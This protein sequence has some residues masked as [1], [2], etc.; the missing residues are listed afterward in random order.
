MTATEVSYALFYDQTNMADSAAQLLG[1]NDQRTFIF[2][3]ALHM[4][5]NFKQQKKKKKEEKKYSKLTTTEMN[6]GPTNIR[7]KLQRQRSHRPSD[8]QVVRQN[9]GLARHSDLLRRSVART[10]RGQNRMPTTG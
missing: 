4:P 5:P 10:V 2:L 6:A 9:I 7:K 3:R 8:R 1:R